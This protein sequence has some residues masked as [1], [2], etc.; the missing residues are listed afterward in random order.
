VVTE[1]DAARLPPG[2]PV[3]VLRMELVVKGAEPLLTTL[4]ALIP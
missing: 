3:R 2:A 4:R 1:K